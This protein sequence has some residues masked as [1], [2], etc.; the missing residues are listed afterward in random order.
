MDSVNPPA[1]KLQ[2]GD[3]DYRSHSDKFDQ[4]MTFSQSPLTFY[5][6]NATTEEEEMIVIHYG[7]GD[8]EPRLL[9]SGEV[10][11]VKTGMELFM[12]GFAFAQENHV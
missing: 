9:M 7:Y 8:S 11:D 6:V 10:D 5:I 1:P 3:R 4:T 2:P 12:A